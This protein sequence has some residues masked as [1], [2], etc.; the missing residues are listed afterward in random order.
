[1][2]VT[3]AIWSIVA[4]LAVFAAAGVVLLVQALVIARTGI[5]PLPLR[6]RIGRYVGPLGPRATLL[7]P[8][9]RVLVELVSAT[10]GFPGL[11]WF[12]SGRVWAGLVLMLGGSALVWGLVPVALAFSGLLLKSPYAA[13]WYLPIV[14]VVSATALALDQRFVR[15]MSR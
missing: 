5:E 4:L 1:M 13:T 3:V 8:W 15:R 12:S 14:G 11:G 10:C 6:Q 2:I 9:N 7:S